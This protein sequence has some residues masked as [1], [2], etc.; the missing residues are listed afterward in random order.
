MGR[1][2]AFIGPV[3]AGQCSRSESAV[4]RGVAAGGHGARP[5]ARCSGVLA[6]GRAP[7]VPQAPDE[8]AGGQAPPSQA[9]PPAPLRVPG[10]AGQRHLRQ[11]E[12][13]ARALRKAGKEE[14]IPPPPL[15]WP[16][17]EAAPGISSAAAPSWPWDSHWPGR[18]ATRRW[19]EQRERSPGLWAALLRRGRKW[20]QGGPFPGSEQQTP[21]GFLVSEGGRLICL[22][23]AAPHM[24]TSP[25]STLCVAG[26]LL[27]VG[28]S[29]EAV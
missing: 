15:P 14:G 22:P 21:D 2:V 7:Q 20:L 4:R 10:D 23:L 12:E 25:P 17:P 11:G 8:E 9:Q 5:G 26:F 24:P 19:R 28:E 1:F 6:G 29:P 3:A 27:G 16:G 13:G 18:Q